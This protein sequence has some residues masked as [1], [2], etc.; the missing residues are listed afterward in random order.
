VPRTLILSLATS[1][2]FRADDATVKKRAK[3][4]EKSGE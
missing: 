1:A 2:T 3:R 4:P